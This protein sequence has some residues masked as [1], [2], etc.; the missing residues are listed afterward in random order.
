M[1]FIAQIQ[2]F[3]YPHVEKEWQQIRCHTD[4]ICKFICNSPSMF[5][6]AVWGSSYK[7]PID[8]VELY[9]SSH[10]YISKDYQHKTYGEIAN[11]P[12]FKL[13]KFII[14]HKDIILNAYDREQKY[15]EVKDL[16]DNCKYGV[17]YI[18]K[19]YM[20]FTLLGGKETHRN[21]THS[22]IESIVHLML[23]DNYVPLT[24]YDIIGG[25]HYIA[26]DD[27]LTKY[28]VYK[29]LA[30]G[31]GDEV[32]YDSL[33]ILFE[34]LYPYTDEI[35]KENARIEKEEHKYYVEDTFKEKIEGNP[36]RL[37]HLFDF[38]NA[39]GMNDDF[40]F[41][42]Q[43]FC[44]SN[45]ELLDK[46]I[47]DNVIN[48]V[49]KWGERQREFS[50]HCIDIA[51]SVMPSFGRY[52]Y[53]L[54]LEYYD[55]KLNP[56]SPNISIWQFFPMSFCL[57]NSLDYSFFPHTKKNTTDLVLYKECSK[58]IPATYCLKI[59]DFIKHIA[60]ELNEEDKLAVCFKETIE[61]GES[62]GL[63]S[64]ANTLYIHDAIE[65]MKNISIIEYKNKDFSPI[66]KFVSDNSNHNLIKI[67]IIDF[68]T[69]NDDLKDSCQS[70]INHSH[71]APS[72]IYLS[73]LKE[74]SSDEMREIID[75]KNKEVEVKERKEKEK[76]AKEQVE[77]KKKERLLE[78][79][80]NCIS[81]WESSAMGLKY[82]YLWYYYPTNCEL[83]I[84]ESSEEKVWEV[85]NLVWDFKNTKGKTLQADHEYSLDV[86]VPKVADLLYKTFGNDCKEL[87]LVCITAATEEN[88]QRRYKDFAIRLCESNNMTNGNEYINFVQDG[89]SKHDCPEGQVPKKPIIK[90][91]EKFFKDRFVV[92]FD[93][94][95]TKGESMELYRRKLNKIGA[96]V[97]CGITIAK[98]KHE[99]IGVKHN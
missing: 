26:D 48:K 31:N 59:I 67:V 84:S 23:V 61:E 95:R 2:N 27:K 99:Y 9:E 72:I 45:I 88:T 13:K 60:S 16:L 30:A 36:A 96:N 97:V 66:T 44:V 77:F 57:D 80:P 42:W 4:A 10:K 43:E 6:G 47:H 22:D 37:K 54:R 50:G 32:E 25:E 58:V 35:R 68:Y 82:N 29:V 71:H 83:N 28:D 21:V 85:R 11:N 79:L 7:N 1:S 14:E 94:V 63:G 56:I 3:L 53:K 64:L 98:T 90:F 91:D 24:K 18:C 49:D 19:K 41:E 92:L 87:T 20:P 86:I 39:Q 81:K 34:K 33:F 12:P 38:L 55:E 65:E 62:M 51:K 46:Y 52:A 17:T 40:S 73:L 76:Q 8:R 69:N 93:D 15:K 75:R 78:D 70:I 5:N 89:V 74:Y